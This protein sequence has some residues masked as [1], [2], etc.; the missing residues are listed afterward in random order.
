M[1]HLDDLAAA[2]VDDELS[3]D[4]RDRALAHLTG[5]ASCRDEVE[6]QRLLKIRL[7]VSQAPGISTSLTVRLLAIPSN[8]PAADP[9]RTGALPQS[10]PRGIRRPAARPLPFARHRVA[11]S[12]SALAVVLGGAM[13]LGGEQGGVQPP[14]GSFLEQH[15]ATNGQLPLNDP[16]IM[17]TSFTGR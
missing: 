15:S 9:R 8:V 2:L 14:V 13:L 7:S 6:A 11:G 16:A 10:G 1:T 3:H 5:C 12:L 17:L 4:Q